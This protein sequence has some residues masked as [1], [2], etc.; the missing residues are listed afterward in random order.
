[1][2]K[3][4]G[5]GITL[6]NK[7]ASLLGYTKKLDNKYCERCFKTIHYNEELPVTSLDNEKIIRKIN[8]LNYPVLFIT[9]LFSLNGHVIDV[10]KKI[11]NPKTLVINKCDLIP[12]NLKLEHLKDNIKESFQIKDDILFISVKKDINLNKIEDLMTLGNLILVGE[13]SS[14]KSSLINKLLGINLT[15]SSYSN[16]TLEFIKLKY[17]VNVIYDTPGI[18]INKEKKNIAKINVYTKVLKKD[19]V[20]TIDNLKIKG[21]GNLTLYIPND[22]KVVS[23]KE[24]ISMSKEYHLQKSDLE[25]SM[26]GFILIKNPVHL[27][28][29]EDLMVRDSLISR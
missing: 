11:K 20:L 14:G 1:M 16:T 26:G 21:E 7:D 25:L 17:G 8:K 4:L 3:C 13:T 6:Q 10:F 24:D 29:N 15:T 27:Y 19:Y 23:K 22:V 28:S 9:D 2:S 18:I 5:C 12:D